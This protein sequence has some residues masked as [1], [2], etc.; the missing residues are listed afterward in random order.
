[1]DKEQRSDNSDC[2]KPSILALGARL[3]MSH[4]LDSSAAAAARSRGPG[5]PVDGTRFVL[6]RTSHPGNVGAPPAR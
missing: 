6:V 5:R 2:G 3:A 4:P 1:M